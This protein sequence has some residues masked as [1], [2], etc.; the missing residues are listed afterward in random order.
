MNTGK[1][2][3]AILSTDAGVTEITTLIYGNEARQGVDFPCV[4]YNIISAVPINTK[5]GSAAYSVRVQI[6]SLADSY[7]AASA[8]NL[9][10][11]AALKDKALGTY[12]GVYVQTIKMDSSQDLTGT[13]GFDGINR[14]STDFIVYHNG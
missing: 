6:D 12:G 10:V 9:A 11:I 4:V 7:D 1:A 8:L 13:D 2:I 5:S 14:I 3:Y